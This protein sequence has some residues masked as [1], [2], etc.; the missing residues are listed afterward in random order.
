[1]KKV[2]VGLTRLV[3]FIVFTVFTFAVLVYFAAMV[4]L[5][6]DIIAI[7]INFFGL[8][9]LNKLIGALIA[10]LVVGYLTMA[11]YKIPG[12]AKMVIDTGLDLVSI[13]KTRVEAFNSV[14]E[15]VKA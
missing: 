2:N 3:Q 14:V 4:I 15:N 10:V 5:P 8:F 1:M 7:M 6:L 11:A 13:A 9:G 12:L